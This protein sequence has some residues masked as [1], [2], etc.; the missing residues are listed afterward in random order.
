MTMKKN[1][2]KLKKILKK[3]HD[4]ALVMHDGPDA[5]AMGS[6]LALEA[7]LKNMGHNVSVIS[8]SVIPHSLK[9]M[10]GSKE[11]LPAVDKNMP[12]I[13]SLIES[14]QTLIC[15]DLNS[16]SRVHHLAESIENSSATCVMI[17]HHPN[18]ED[19]AD[20]MICD[21]HASSTAE[22]VFDI[23]HG[24][25][26]HKR[27][28]AGIGN[29]LYAG[30]MTDTGQ[31]KHATTS[32]KTHQTV[33]KLIERGVDVTRV[34]HNIYDN[35]TLQRLKFLGYVLSKKLVVLEE[36]HTAYFTISEK[37]RRRFDVRIAETE[38]L[39]D[40]ALSIEGIA[41]GAVI[42]EKNDVVRLSLRSVN[43]FSVNQL[44]REHFDGGGHRNAAGGT[45]YVS[46]KETAEKF[47]SLLPSLA[48]ELKASLSMQ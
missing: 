24:I 9:W 17:D 4:I 23:L 15:I 13:L 35:N 42:S 48:T 8:P 14:A 27:L 36:Y 37:D 26:Q 29:L 25:K 43:D 41:L 10:Y 40:Y 39:V 30:I 18:P 12:R 46:L 45:S 7:I 34:A 22:I 47:E 38:G 28:D 20:I 33:A 32:K 11:I 6:S 3:P 16:L 1:I 44:A 19:F 2:T 31:F 5:D 21:H